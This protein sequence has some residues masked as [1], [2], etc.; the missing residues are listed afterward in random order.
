MN[1]HWLAVI[2]A[3][4]VWG[5]TFA[6]T[7]AL[8]SDFSALEILAL[9]FGLAFAALSL[10]SLLRPRRLCAVSG[11]VPGG[12]TL[13]AAMGFTGI[14]AYQLLENCAIH[15]TNAGNVALLVSFCPILTAL[16]ARAIS[17]DRHLTRRFAAGSLIAMSGVALVSWNGIAEFE[18]RPA[19]DLMAMAAM[20]SWGMYSI[21][22]ERANARGVSPV[23]AT[24]RAF[25]WSLLMMA[26]VLLAGAS[27]CW[28]GA[29]DGSLAV[30][31]DAAANARRFS[32]SL[33][34][35]NIAFLGLLA[36]AACFSLWSSACRALGMVKTTVFLYA[37]PVVGVLFAAVCLGERVTALELLGGA[38][39]LAGVAIATR[40]PARFARAACATGENMLK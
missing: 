33:N 26:P 21:L 24:R 35:M 34:V 23:A 32:D 10:A 28:P 4:S 40:A 36:S 13:F 1:I 27:G 17:G 19:G 14:F 25:G 7:R 18:L 38:V 12:E 9:R 15:Y 20:V 11:A 6:S 8:L 37:T 30:T 31:L 2:V 3:I 16:L 22:L 29:M 5:M 39:I